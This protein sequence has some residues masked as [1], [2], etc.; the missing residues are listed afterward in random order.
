[1]PRSA[2]TPM[3]IGCDTRPR[4]CRRDD[5]PAWHPNKIILL[6]LLPLDLTTYHHF[7]RFCMHFSLAKGVNLIPDTVCKSQWC[8]QILSRLRTDLR[9][10][11]TKQWASSD[12]LIQSAGSISNSARYHSDTNMALGPI[13]KM[14]I[15]GQIRIFNALN[16]DGY[17]TGN[18]PPSGNYVGHIPYC[19]ILV[20][21]YLKGKTFLFDMDRLR[22][23]SS[24]EKLLNFLFSMLLPYSFRLIWVKYMVTWLLGD[25]ITE[26]N[27]FIP[28]LNLAIS[29]KICGWDEYNHNKC[30]AGIYV[31]IL[32]WIARDYAHNKI[33]L[34]IHE[35]E[36]VAMWK[37]L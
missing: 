34:D 14:Y 12:A 13:L 31:K 16:N 33:T 28:Q 20:C 35:K 7:I 2:V 8:R 1:M 21:H 15:P 25:N 23:F 24:I 10:N 5:I 3:A 26:G 19:G 6:S 17:S 18:A 22:L 30:V 4:H 27:I 11:P 29:A 36:R 32:S 37:Q 9:E